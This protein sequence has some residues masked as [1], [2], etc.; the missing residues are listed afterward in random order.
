M[1]STREH[2]FLIKLVLVGSSGVGKTCLIQRYNGD[3]YNPDIL[4]S[5]SG[6]W[7]VRKIEVGGKRVKLRIWDTSG[8]ER[9]RPL[10][11]SY[12]R[13]SNGVF[14][15]YDVAS[16]GSFNDI[17]SYWSQSVNQ[18]APEKATKILVG[19]KSDLIE[20]RVVSTKRGEEL[21]DK[22][23]IPFFEVSAKNNLELGKAFH[24]MT[25]LI[26]KTLMNDNE[27]GDSQS[28][29]VVDPKANS[30]SPYLRNLAGLFARSRDQSNRASM[31]N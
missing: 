15:V 10:T 9:L 2:N 4:P 5:I 20:R 24:T 29:V 11:T 27:P 13:Y 31:L 17:Q 14:L 16:E 3:P 1:E 28:G 7:L 25:L 21:A 30:K 8:V 26:T 19:N 6:D 18:H 22:L 23:G 12:Y